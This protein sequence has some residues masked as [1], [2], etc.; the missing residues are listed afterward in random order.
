MWPFALLLDIGDEEHVE[1][2]QPIVFPR[3]IK[4]SAGRRQCHELRM[5]HIK[6]SPVGHGDFEWPSKSNSL[7]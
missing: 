4:N 5:G 7:S 6:C 2:F 1:C 3:D